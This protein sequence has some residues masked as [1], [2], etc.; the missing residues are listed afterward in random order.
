MSKAT[1][2]LIMF[3]ATALLVAATALAQR[4]FSTVEIKATKVAGTVWMLTGAGGNIGVSVGEDGVVVIDDQYAPLA[5]KIEAAVKT[6]SDKP[7]RF[8]LNT[9]FHGDHTG[10]NEYF[11][12]STT[13]IAQENV[14]NRLKSGS[15]VHGTAYPAAPKAALPVITF[16]DSLTVHLNGEDV[17]AIHAPHGHTD[18][19]AMIFFPQSNVVHMGDLLFNGTFPFIDLENG[20]SVKGV[21]AGCE[22]VLASTPDDVKI[23]P[24][25][26]PLADKTVVRKY[27]E[28]LKAT[29]AAVAKGLAAGKT[30]DQLKADKVLAEWDEAWGKGFIKSDEWI[31]TLVADAGKKK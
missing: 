24:G 9:H 1:P 5:P 17:R 29:S 20:G 19:D 30:A 11:G 10:S 28:M 12:K 26:G 2:K 21:I 22:K 16:D 25:H 6:I 3:L 23:I 18:G 7:L 14:R 27:V 4:D 13:I 31:D 15:S 8:I